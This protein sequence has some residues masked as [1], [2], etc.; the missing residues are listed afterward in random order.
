MANGHWQRKID[1]SGGTKHGRLYSSSH[2]KNLY[3][4]TKKAKLGSRV[5]LIGELDVHNFEFLSANPSPQL[6]P[7]RLHHPLRLKKETTF[8]TRYWRLLIQTTLKNDKN[9]P[10]LSKITNKPLNIRLHQHPLQR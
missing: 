4:R 6:T 8:I 2:K 1:S 10:I 7:L 3:E 5:F 9:L